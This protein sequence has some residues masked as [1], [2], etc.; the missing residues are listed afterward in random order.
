M[1][2]ISVLIT[3]IKNEIETIKHLNNCP[4]PYEVVTSTKLGIGYARNYAALQAKGKILVFFDDDLKL[5]PKIWAVILKIK[6]GSFFVQLSSQ[7]L[8]STRCLVIHRTDFMK[9]GGFRNEI[10]LSGEDRD[11]CLNALK[12]GLKMVGLPKNLTFHVDHPIRSQ[13]SR[14]NA[15]RMMFEQAKVVASYGAYW[16]N[17]EGFIMFF[18]PLPY[19]KGNKKLYC[20]GL[21]FWKLIIRNLMCMSCV[22]VGNKYRD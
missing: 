16:R 10:L 4:V 12:K 21:I 3:S 5:D 15:L 8:P 1:V 19:A 9:I 22:F 2:L 14:Y 11:F 13:K 17:L 6:E 7:K 20:P 18:F